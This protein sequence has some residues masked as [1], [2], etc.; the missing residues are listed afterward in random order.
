MPK[1]AVILCL[2]LFMLGTSISE[3]KVLNSSQAD[4]L[5]VLLDGLKSETLTTQANE[6]SKYFAEMIEKTYDSL[7]KERESS[8][9]ASAQFDL[10]IGAIK[11]AG[12]TANYS[13]QNRRL[14]NQVREKY[15]SNIQSSSNG[16][17]TFLHEW[18][19]VD[20]AFKSTIETLIKNLGSI[21]YSPLSVSV[22][23]IDDS[24]SF[25]IWASF[26]SPVGFPGVEPYPS[27]RLEK[28]EADAGVKS[29][30]G[31]FEIHQN[32]RQRLD[33]ATLPKNLDIGTIAYHL[34]TEDNDKYVLFATIQI[35]KTPPPEPPQLEPSISLKGW[36]FRY[37]YGERNH[38]TMPGHGPAW[39]GKVTI[40]P[41]FSTR[42]SLLINQVGLG[43]FL[44]RT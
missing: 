22:E 7:Y 26:D 41:R 24:R 17:Q 43:P 42:L 3:A 10:M 2:A 39:N 30:A 15:K 13:D 44:S 14:W 33:I 36:D 25:E 40:S 19:G 11:K 34:T 28:I 20:P 18:R 23:R 1:S 35:K 21:D 31:T 4:L 38:V 29:R 27:F 8:R 12:G 32:S 9:G 6:R 5:Q 37:T 16:L